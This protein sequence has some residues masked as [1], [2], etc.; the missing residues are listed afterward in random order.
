MTKEQIQNALQSQMIEE[1]DPPLQ[2]PDASI[3]ISRHRNVYVPVTYADVERQ[4][5]CFE[6]CMV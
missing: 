6:I 3:K 1:K 5:K 2:Y 4:K